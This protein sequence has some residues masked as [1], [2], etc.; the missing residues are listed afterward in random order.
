MG[1]YLEP[2]SAGTTTSDGSVVGGVVI[3][4]EECAVNF[5]SLSKALVLILYAPQVN[6]PNVLILSLLKCSNSSQYARH[7]F[8]LIASKGRVFVYV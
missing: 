4:N 2:K 6:Y 5:R 8:F 7:L 1:T 3:E